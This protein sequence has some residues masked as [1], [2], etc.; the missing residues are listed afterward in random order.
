MISVNKTS[1]SFSHNGNNRK[2]PATSQ[3]INKSVTD[4]NQLTASKISNKMNL[5]YLHYIL[6]PKE[7]SLLYQMFEAQRKSYEKGDWATEVIEILSDIK[8][9]MTLEKIKE[10]KRE[11]FKKLVHE[12]VKREAYDYLTKKQKAGRKGQYIKYSEGFTMA[13][14]LLPNNLLTV[15][16]QKE[17]F[18]L[19]TRMNDLPNNFGKDER[20]ET[21]C[22]G[23]MTNEHILECT[24]LNKGQNEEI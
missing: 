2:L 21:E 5:N 3:S 11:E 16:D 4:R 10:M 20:C 14:Y 18:S 8:I 23:K 6:Q 24:I 22:V 13:D 17:I 12:K 9:D 15:S 7:D 1:E 19:R